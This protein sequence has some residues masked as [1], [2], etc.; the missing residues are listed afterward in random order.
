[1][2]PLSRFC[3]SLP[4]IGFCFQDAVLFDFFYL[5][6]CCFQLS[7]RH[8]AGVFQI[9]VC[10]FFYSFDLATMMQSCFVFS[11]SC[12]VVEPSSVLDLVCIVRRC[13]MLSTSRYAAEIS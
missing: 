5:M 11:A 10:L 7:L 4:H 8:V 9:N 2:L 12:Y 3:P 6:L 1:M 13:L